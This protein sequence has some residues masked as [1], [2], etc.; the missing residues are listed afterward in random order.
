MLYVPELDKG[1][2]RRVV[3]HEDINLLIIIYL[4]IN[5]IIHTTEYVGANLNTYNECI[6]QKQN[7]KSLIPEYKSYNMINPLKCFFGIRGHVALDRN[8]GPGYDTLLL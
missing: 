7:T 1:L 4:F 3:N 5:L 6:K 8:P 2:F